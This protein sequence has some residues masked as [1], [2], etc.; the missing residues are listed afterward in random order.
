M[1]LDIDPRTAT[2]AFDSPSA[3]RRRARVLIVDDERGPRESL[4]MILSGSHEVTTAEDAAEA[5]DVLRTEEI[6]LVTVDLN[7]PGMKGDE[8]MRTVRAESPETEIIIITGCGSIET[9][10]E[11]IRHGVF[12]YLIKPFDVVQVTASVERALARRE[13]R[14]RTISFL[15]EV[16]RLLGPD[17]DAQ[18]TLQELALD[19][20]AQERV[21]SLLT[22]P[23]LQRGV[24]GAR[25]GGPNALAFLEVLAETIET[26]DLF[27]RGH[28]R[29]VAHAADL[30]AARLCLAR[31]ERDHVR[32]AAFLHDIGKVGAT[33]DVLAGRIL[34]EPDRLESIQTHPAMGERLLR[35]L[36]LSPTV[37]ATVRH[38][39]E[40][41]DGRGYPDGLAGEDIPLAAR[42]IA[43]V[44]AFDAM[45]CERPYRRARSRDE[46]VAELR[47]HARSQ[48]DPH[49][50]DLFCD[51]VAT[52]ALEP[53]D[54]NAA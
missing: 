13:S 8:L 41:Y 32:M 33:S 2:S 7:M 23:M 46:A 22:D 47:A 26:R 31:E 27:M 1:S 49:L 21:R 28:A 30:V 52:G 39:H 25:S 24:A 14:G 42:I 4:R 40:R 37:T 18:I 12:D 3:S 44:D 48:F 15:E 16:G 38:H 11:G 17:R 6:D 20:L 35:P 36:G 34:P 51:L 54:A 10:V 5:L 9:A 50:V 29:R 45:T 43:I 19:T 53:I